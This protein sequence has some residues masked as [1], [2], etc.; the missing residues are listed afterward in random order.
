MAALNGIVGKGE[1]SGPGVEREG[2][3]PTESLPRWRASRG[4][5][6]VGDTAWALGETAAAVL[7]CTGWGLAMELD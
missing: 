2:K 3:P 4:P 6:P 7:A 1:R 5:L